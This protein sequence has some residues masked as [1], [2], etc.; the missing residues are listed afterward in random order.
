MKYTTKKGYTG[1]IRKIWTDDK[2]KVLGVVGEIGDL[3]KEGILESC[4]QYSHDTW[5]CIPVAD[6]DTAAGFGAT[7][8]E[9]VRNAIFRK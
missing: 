5:M 1:T 4:T 7:R 2:S 3:L 9:A 6:F 8:D